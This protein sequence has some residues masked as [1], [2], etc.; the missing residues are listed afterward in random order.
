MMDRDVVSRAAAAVRE[1]YDGTS[2]RAATTRTLVLLRA[3]TR[4]RARRR[5]TGVVLGLA[6]TLVVTTAW[7]AVVRPAWGEFLL[8]LVG[9]AS[10]PMARVPPAAVREPAAAS[11]P[12]AIS[13]PSA[14]A[15]PD[16]TESAPPPSSSE[17]PEPSDG[18][19]EGRRPA[20]ALAMNTPL[21]ARDASARAAVD[22]APD[23]E[24]N[25]YARAHAAH[26][27]RHDPADAL[28]GWD[29]YLAIYPHGRFA[30]EAEYNRAIALIRLGRRAE[31][32]SA[33]APFATAARGG[34]RQREARELLDALGDANDGA[35]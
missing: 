9:A 32:R 17:G 31:A 6:A 14:P 18:R 26:F 2:R 4:K 33:L 11:V 22:A 20:V 5:R 24:D 29:A 7:A 27:V 13:A 28:S 1:A 35:P 3:G 30:L 16:P 15:A 25:L 8:H 10:T 19:R 21:P 12:P 34:Y 23:P